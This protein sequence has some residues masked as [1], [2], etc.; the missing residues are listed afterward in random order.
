MNIR[1]LKYQD[2]G[3]GNQGV[4][5]DFQAEGSVFTDDVIMTSLLLILD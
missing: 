1:L 2:R 5:Q 4:R 3:G